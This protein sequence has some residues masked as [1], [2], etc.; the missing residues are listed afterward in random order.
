M[1]CD[2][3][4]FTPSEIQVESELDQQLANMRGQLAQ[5]GIGFDLYCQMLNTTEE[6][7]REEARGS[8]ETAIRIQ[9]A[10]EQIAYSEQLEATDEEISR[11]IRR[12]TEEQRIVGQN[13]EALRT[14]GQN[15]EEQT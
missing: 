4:D 5:Q 2:S 8:A 14:I 13:T 12:N 10:I 15:T 1:A 11:I 9:T 7:L 6:K 3:L